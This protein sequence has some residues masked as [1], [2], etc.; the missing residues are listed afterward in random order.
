MRELLA[1]GTSN[2]R[3]QE[4]DLDR[5]EAERKRQLP[6]H[7]HLNQDAI[8]SVHLVSAMMAEVP[9]LA[10]H[11]SANRKKVIS[12]AFRRLFDAH[13]RQAFNGPPE[14]TRDLIMAATRAMRIGEWEQCVGHIERL[15]MW[16]LMH[17]TVAAY[18]KQIVS[19]RIKEETCKT[20]LL[21]YQHN[22]TTIQLQNLSAM[23]DLPASIVHRIASKLIVNEQLSGQWDMITHSIV[24]TSATSSRLGRLS[25]Y[26]TDK[27]VALSEQN[28]RM[29]ESKHG[30]TQFKQS[31]SYNRSFTSN[32]AGGSGN[33]AA[34]GSS[35]Y[36]RN[37]SSDNSRRGGRTN[38]SRGGGGGGSYRSNNND[39]RGGQRRTE[40]RT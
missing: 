6:F 26:F 10:V 14:N 16:A 33:A 13:Q 22:F 18:V 3:W 29:L 7:M 12:K 17:P 32:A 40:S 4:R 5:E 2:S 38:T 8:E 25:A 34:S 39:R 1:Q 31:H 27:C 36:V 23:F 21:T 24:F 11:G 30:F 15:R 28:E 20:Y 35:E 37:D 19:A 9:N